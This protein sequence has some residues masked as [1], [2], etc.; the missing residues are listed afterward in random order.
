[1]FGAHPGRGHIMAAWIDASVISED[2]PL[3]VDPALDIY[4]PEHGPPF[5][6]DFVA[7]VRAAQR[8]R[9]ERITARAH[10]RLRYL[11]GR[12]EGPRDEAF[13]VYRTM[14]DPRVTDLTLDP[15][16]RPPESIWGEPR[17][18]NYGANN[19]GRFTSLTSWLSQ[20]SPESR[21]DGPACLARTS[22]PVLNLEFSADSAVLP[23]DIELW[24]DAAGSREDYHRIAKATHYMDGQPELLAQ[25]VELISGWARGL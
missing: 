5:A 17:A 21:A 7:T 10:A 19:V 14:A 23:G 15:N 13:L 1:M 24:S 8:A 12:K 22:V 16:D 18:I 6:P 2:D 20:W 25:V 4:N 3:G 11:H 9:V